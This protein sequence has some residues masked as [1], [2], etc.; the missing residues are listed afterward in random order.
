MISIFNSTPGHRFLHTLLQVK[1]FL[2][3]RTSDLPIFTVSHALS[4]PQGQL[5]QSRHIGDTVLHVFLSSQSQLSVLQIW[6]FGGDLEGRTTS[7]HV[8]PHLEWNLYN[9]KPE[10]EGGW[11]LLVFLGC[12]IHP[13]YIFH[14]IELVW[15]AVAP[16]SNVTD[17][18][19]FYWDL[20]DFSWINAFKFIVVF[21][22]FSPVLSLFFWGEDLMNSLY[23]HSG[24]PISYT[25]MFW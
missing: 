23:I 15:M 20:V 8:P 4:P 12:P 14:N 1:L 21:N 11:E 17:S 10:L 18:H 2:L 7:F 5:E 22:I 16:G 3:G 24:R 9:M 13:E 25:I 19:C 6:G